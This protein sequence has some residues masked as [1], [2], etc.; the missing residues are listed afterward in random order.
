MPRHEDQFNQELDRMLHEGQ[1]PDTPDSEHDAMLDIAAELRHADFSQDS[2]IRDS[3]REKLVNTNPKDEKRMLNITTKRPM[4]A[5]LPSLNVLAAVLAVVLVGGFLLA[6]LSAPGGPKP[7]TTD[8]NSGAATDEQTAPQQQDA[9]AT[10]PPTSI[11]T[12]TPIAPAPAGFSTYQGACEIIMPQGSQ[13]TTIIADGAVA[14]YAVPDALTDPILPDVATDETLLLLATAVC[15]ADTIYHAVLLAESG[16]VGWVGGA[17]IRLQSLPNQSVITSSSGEMPTP[18]VSSSFPT[19][20]AIATACNNTVVTRMAIGRRGVV[21]DAFAGLELRLRSAP[22]LFESDVI[23]SFAAGTTFIV[24]AGPECEDGI[25]FWQVEIESSGETG[26]FS[27]IFQGE[28]VIEPAASVSATD[29]EICAGGLPTR[30]ESGDRGVVNNDAFPGLELRLRTAPSLFE[31]EVIATYPAGTTFTVF[32]DAVCADGLYFYR[33][34]IDADDEIGFFA[35]TF[36][37]EYV[38]APVEAG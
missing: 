16:Q 12:A 25:P 9:T 23:D 8:N 26:W 17:E 13:I 37:G 18:V 19:A 28:Y 2:Q 38:I 27:E 11:P 5:Q 10:L 29:N 14:L 15:E 3:L 24:V 20:T 4:L 36:E 7:P 30:L 6:V 31:S 21:T 22:T 33:V 35:E 1:R 34:Q 32:D